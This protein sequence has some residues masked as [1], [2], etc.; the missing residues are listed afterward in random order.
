MH[1]SSKRDATNALH[2]S[3]DDDGT[4]ST[5]FELSFDV[6]QDF[7]ATKPTE[8]VYGVVHFTGDNADIRPLLDYTWHRKYTDARVE[9]QDRLIQRLSSKCSQ[10]CNQMLPW[11]VF[12]AGAMGA[13]KGH[14][15]KWMDRNGYL[16]LKHFIIIDPD[17]IRQKLPEW[18]LYLAANPSTA[19]DMTQKEAG[20]IAEIMGYRALRDRHNVVFDGSLRD[21]NWYTKYFRRLRHEF[22]GVRIAILH[23]VAERE[24]VLRNAVERGR[25]T[26][27]EVPV[28]LIEESM[29][30]VPKSV[31]AL[32]VEADFVCRVLNRKGLNP[33]LLRE[34]GAPNPPESVDITWDLIGKLWTNIDADGDGALSQDEVEV[35]IAQG[36]LS[37]AVLRSIDRNNDGTISKADFEAAREKARQSATRRFR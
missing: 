19:G 18:G 13:G 30:Q 32:A 15:T 16:P 11:V 7:D 33:Q 3:H 36:L 9:L 25:I 1:A 2:H 26:G 14:V 28:L 34:E 22:P 6:P 35:A 37:R 17:A 27:R 24:E 8:D 10:C 23:V 21:T 29:A 20:C 31:R 4:E 5:N 12:T